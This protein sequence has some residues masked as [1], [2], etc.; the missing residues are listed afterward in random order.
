MEEKKFKHC[1]NSGNSKK[2]IQL[3]KFIPDKKFKPCLYSLEI[4]VRNKF[5]HCLN[6]LKIK[7]SKLV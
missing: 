3:F 5:K 1:L 2:Y 6:S 7:N 4:T